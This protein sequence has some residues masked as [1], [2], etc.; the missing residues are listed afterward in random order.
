MLPKSI[1]RIQ[2]FIASLAGFVAVLVGLYI[3]D[4]PY[5]DAWFDRLAEFTTP[6]TSGYARFVAPVDMLAHS[7]EEVG[8]TWL[9]EAPCYC[10]DHA[11]AGKIRS[12]RSYLGQ[13]DL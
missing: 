9:E 5:L 12:E 6:N 13:T 2:V 10:G 1:R 7:F 3:A 4:I 11:A 8:S